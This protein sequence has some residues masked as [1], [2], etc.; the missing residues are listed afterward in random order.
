MTTVG[1]VALVVGA[2]GTVLIIV[3]VVM[4]LVQRVTRAYRDAVRTFERV[5]PLLH[6]LAEHQEVT[7]REL[8]ALAERRGGD[9]HP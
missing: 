3:F 5:Q 2:L 6:E 8:A 1:A 9:Q 7:R 4:V